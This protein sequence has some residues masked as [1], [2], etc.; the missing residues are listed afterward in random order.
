MDNTFLRICAVQRMADLCRLWMLRCLGILLTCFFTFFS[1]N[2]VAPIIT[3]TT[4]STVTLVFSVIHS[5]LYSFCVAH[6]VCIQISR[7]KCAAAWI[8]LL[9]CF[10]MPICFIMTWYPL[11]SLFGFDTSCIFSVPYLMMYLQ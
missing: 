6:Q 5:G 1:A 3:E 7:C 4:H 9:K 10:L 2:S 11:H 8:C